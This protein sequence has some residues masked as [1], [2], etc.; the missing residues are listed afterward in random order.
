MGWFV[1]GWITHG[2]GHPINQVVVVAT[3]V[4][5]KARHLGTQMK[6]KGEK[7]N[8]NEGSQPS[9][10]VIGLGHVDQKDGQDVHILNVHMLWKNPMFEEDI[11]KVEKIVD[12]KHE[13]Q[14]LNKV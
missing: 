6:S 7:S 11:V 9:L 13:V 3:T 1:K 12:L 4:K 10:E 2:N 5:E 14:K 8:V